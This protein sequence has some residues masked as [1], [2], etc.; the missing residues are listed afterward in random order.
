MVSFVILYRYCN[1]KQQKSI[2]EVSMKDNRNRIKTSLILQSFSPLFVLLLIQH[3]RLS[4]FKSV[5]KFFKGIILKDWSVLSLAIHSPLFGN[6]IISII[7]IAGLLWSVIVFFGFRQY[8]QYN[9]SSEGERINVIGN[10]KESG[11]AFLMTFILPLLITDVS[12]IRNLIVFIVIMAMLIWFLKKTNLFYQNPV[13]LALNYN[14]FEFKVIPQTD[15]EKKE[16]FGEVCIG[17]T[18]GIIPQN[19]MCVAKKLIGDNVYFIFGEFEGEE[20]DVR[21]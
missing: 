14:I 10:K 5:F 4:V 15:D 16:E 13:L 9:Y 7:S 18:K 1:G 8:Q 2:K 17:I 20:K 3:C 21:N 6:V 12:D 19:G 11:V